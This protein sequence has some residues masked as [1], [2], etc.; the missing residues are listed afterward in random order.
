[1]PTDI[2]LVSMPYSAITLPSLAL[3]LIESYIKEYDHN[4]DV[5]YANVEF[6]A[7][8]GIVAYNHIDTSFY[9]HL[10]GEWTFSR[11]AFPEKILDDEGYFALFSD[12]TPEIKAHLLT[13]RDKADAYIN[14]LAMRLLAKQPKIVAC[15]ST[16]QQNCA[17]LALLRKVKSLNPSIITMLGGANCESIMGQTM[18]D[19]FPWLDYVFSGECDEVIGKFVNKLIN[20]DNISR[21]DL[22]IGVI[23]Q[24]RMIQ[25]NDIFISVGEKSKPPRG[26]V[27]D[28]ANVIAPT[29]DSYFN[30]ITDLELSA[31]IQPGLVVETSRGCWWG[32]KKHCTFCGLNGVSMTHR[33]KPAD[34]VIAELALLSDKYQNN[35]FQV[36]DNILPMD[37]MKTVLPDLAESYNYDLFYETKA[38]LKKEHVEKL[39]NAGIK[40]IQPG[41]ESLHDDFL[42]LV[43][44]GAS[45]IQVISALK[46]SRNY[47][48]SV[49]WNIL[50]AAPFEKAH[51][52]YEMADIIPL[53]SHL[54]PPSLELI[55]IRFHRF[56]PYFKNANDYGLTLEP[57]KNYKHIYP[58]TGQALF[59]I[60]YFFD[61]E[62]TRTTDVFSLTCSNV[63]EQAEH[64]LLQE[65]IAEWHSSW[66]EGNTPLLYMS[67]QEEKI[68]IIDT[69]A[70]ATD[71]THELTGIA[72]LVYRLCGE[73]ITMARLQ[74][75]LFEINNSIDE[76]VLAETL[77][78]LV[79]DK[80]LLEL[81]N[82]YMALALE[83]KTPP[84]PEEKD[85]PV[86]YLNL[87]A[88]EA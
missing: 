87:E 4:I 54:Q 9:E 75:K 5:T 25:E 86:G 64:H 63:H 2:C 10:M 27:D 38:N 67:D 76:L 80:L 58:L 62:S 72:A 19:N 78:N 82:C 20:S 77:A 30:T 12:L 7:D 83:G 11:A 46:W 15:T 45:A 68:V 41:F 70:I 40:W 88:V 1:M 44:K 31:V 13:I 53:I 60:A 66:Y 74:T 39:A 52:Y 48:V 43:G 17:S 35:K 81:S 23:P 16:F 6:A 85:Y 51:W 49:L 33:S 3:G 26:Y 42:K 47:G 8:I 61:E 65:K 73:P 84:L 69:R 36:V 21:F 37:Y 22:P 34:K 24:K 18:S 71:F 50:C 59:D 56:S 79:A 29:Y 28:M 57:L 32:A 55:K 14:A